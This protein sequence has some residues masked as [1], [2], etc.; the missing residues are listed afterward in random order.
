MIAL[1]ITFRRRNSTARD[2]AYYD[3]AERESVAMLVRRGEL[4]SACSRSD[5]R[6]WVM[7]VQGRDEQC[8]RRTMQELPTV[9]SGVRGYHLLFIGESVTR[10]S[11]SSSSTFY[12]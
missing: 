3:T 5:G 8:L 2:E 6:G 11:P 10:G 7:V 4:R 9:A 12:L 1:A